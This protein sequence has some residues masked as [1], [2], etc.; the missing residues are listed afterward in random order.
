MVSD[1]A[2]NSGAQRKAL[3]DRISA[4]ISLVLSRSKVVE[5]PQT[6]SNTKNFS[7]NSS[8]PPPLDCFELT[9]SLQARIKQY[10][11]LG[12]R[13]KKPPLVPLT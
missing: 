2:S 12:R 10:M 1:N 7:C 11:N 6:Q 8:A 13:S 9:A 5:M 4:A 3:W